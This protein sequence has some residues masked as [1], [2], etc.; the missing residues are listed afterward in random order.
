MLYND[1]EIALLDANDPV[2]LKAYFAL[3]RI[4]AGEDTVT[5]GGDGQAG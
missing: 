4:A 2:L 1:E 5:D 3:H